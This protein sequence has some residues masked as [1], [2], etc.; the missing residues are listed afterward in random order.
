MLT[1]LYE[2]ALAALISLSAWV[3]VCKLQDEGMLFY[4]YRNLL[5]RIPDWLAHPLGKCDMCLSGQ[6]AFWVFF[7][8]GVYHPVR[9]VF[10]I[11]IAIFLVGLWEF[12]DRKFY[13]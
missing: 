3:F 10:F 6:L 2:L 9:H 5:D 8:V 1:S 13:E 12:L 4:W 11:S 7:L